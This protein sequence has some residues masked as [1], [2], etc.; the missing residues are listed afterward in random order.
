MGASPSHR[1]P[2]VIDRCSRGPLS[3][4]AKGRRCRWLPRARTVV[5]CHG[6]RL[7]TVGRAG[8]GR[9]DVPGCVGLAV[10]QAPGDLA[11]RPSGS[12]GPSRPRRA[13]GAARGPAQSL[14]PTRMGLAATGGLERAM[15]SALATAGLP[16]VVVSRASGP[17]WCPGHG[18]APRQTGGVGRALAPLAAVSRPPPRPLPDAQPHERRA[19]PPGRRPP[20]S[21]RRTAAQHRL[22]GPTECRT[23][24]MTAP[25]TGLQG[26][27]RSASTL[28]GPSGAL[29]FSSTST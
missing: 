10:A 15:P 9:S 28:Q 25:M 3:P 2:D 13:G 1:S 24:P 12:G 27:Q 26:R 4:S 19:A 14:Q 8:V 16:V 17:G 29:I 11:L 21:G 23:Q 6:A 18:A 7:G 5:W 20:L 22:A